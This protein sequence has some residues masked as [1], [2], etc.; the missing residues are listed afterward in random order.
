VLRRGGVLRRGECCAGGCRRRAPPAPSP[1]GARGKAQA[2]PA[3]A[4][5]L[6]ALLHLLQQ[7]RDAV[8]KLRAHDHV[9]L[10]H[11]AQQRLPLLL[12]HAARHHNLERAYVGALAL[13]LRSRGAG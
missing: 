6:A 10:G 7:L 5:H 1:A 12:G 11:A 9:Q 2:G 8:G 13:G 4:A 3:A